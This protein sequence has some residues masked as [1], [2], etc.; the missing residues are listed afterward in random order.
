[1]ECGVTLRMSFYTQMVCG[2]HLYLTEEQFEYDIWVKQP[3]ACALLDS[4]SMVTL[5][6]TEIAGRV[7]PIHKTLIVACIH[8][9][10]RKST[11]WYQ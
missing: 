10:T 11:R 7:G 9:D 3:N 6:Y 5:V 8:G 1:M 4:A 2:A